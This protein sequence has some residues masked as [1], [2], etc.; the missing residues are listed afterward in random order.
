[1]NRLRTACKQG[2]LEGL[3]VNLQSLEGVGF[4]GG[5]QKSPR[6]GAVSMAVVAGEGTSRLLLI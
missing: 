6:R 1:M 3:P 5:S 2:A 4:G